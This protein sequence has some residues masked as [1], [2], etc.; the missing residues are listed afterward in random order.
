MK[1]GGLDSLKRP[2]VIAEIGN[3]HEGQIDVAEQ[4][5][6]E[7]ARCK[8]DAV[9]FQ[10]FRTDHYVSRHDEARYK[11]L[12]SFEL[13]AAQFGDLGRLARSL[14]LLFLSTPFDLASVDI[15]EPLVDAFKISSG[16]INFYPLI[17][18]VTSTGKPVILSTGASNLSLVKKTVDFVRERQSRA[19]GDEPLAVLHCV[20]SYPVPLEQAN[21]RALTTLKSQ[22]RCTIGYSDHTIGIQAVLAAV[23][24]GAE[25][26]EK[27]F[28]LDKHF[29]DFRDHTISADPLEMA[30]LVRQIPLIQMLLGSGE[31]VI[32]S[33]ELAS[34][35]A[36]RRSIVAGK[37]L[38]R[39]HRLDWNDLTWIRPAGGLAPGEE[40]TVIGKALKH[41][42][43][44]GERLEAGDVG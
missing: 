19:N 2:I 36:I 13:T 39:G 30:E 16:D 31:K 6:R 9:K 21:L 24:L 27:H 23:V 29:S 15:L 20:S 28:T 11:R 42:V 22:L 1:L 26:I 4:L 14:G 3:N 25:V 32:Q 35:A 12:K 34:E 33:C 10:T 37:D 44:F 7:A 40:G 8:A 38:L 18:R 43:T 17:D 41:D 5:V